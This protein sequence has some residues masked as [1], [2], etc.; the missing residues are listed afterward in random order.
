MSWW[1][2]DFKENKKVNMKVEYERTP[3]RHLAVQCP[4]CDFWFFGVILLREN[5]YINI[6]L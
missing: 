1:D 3:I 6:S 2:Q 5:V 4:D